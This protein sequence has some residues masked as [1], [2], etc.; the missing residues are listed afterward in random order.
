M[1]RRHYFSVSPMM[2]KWLRILRI[3]TSAL[4][5]TLIPAVIGRGCYSYMS[6]CNPAL[7]EKLPTNWMN[8][9]QKIPVSQN[10]KTLATSEIVISVSPGE[11]IARFRTAAVLSCLKNRFRVKISQVDGSYVKPLLLMVS[12][13]LYS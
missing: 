9:G 11:A 13:I 1:E 6:T 4:H 2:W 10:E 3:R 7:F 8:T 5:I 12:F